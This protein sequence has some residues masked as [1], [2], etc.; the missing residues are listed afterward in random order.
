MC[1]FILW[2]C[3]FIFQHDDTV[4]DR[5]RDVSMSWWCLDEFAMF[6]WVRD[7]EMIFQCMCEIAGVRACVCVCVSVCL[8]VCVSVCLCVCVSVCL[9][10]FVYVSTCLCVCVSVCLCVCVSMCLCVYVS[11]YLCVYVWETPSP[12]TC[13][14]NTAIP[15]NTLYPATPCNTL[16][17]HATPC[18]TLQHTTTYYKHT[19]QHTATHCN[20]H[21]AGDVFSSFEW[22]PDGTKLLY[23]SSRARLQ[24]CYNCKYAY[25]C[26]CEFVRPVLQR[27][28]VC[29]ICIKL[30]YISSRARLRNW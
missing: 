25:V 1:T 2:C 11:V 10:L 22:S 12:M 5:I 7:I 6:E 3:L 26:V 23:V 21:N 19:L 8:C 9:C 17:H 30:L 4:R 20:A 14:P 18:N 13:S 24:N 16:Q 29:C 28:A 27:L 15:C